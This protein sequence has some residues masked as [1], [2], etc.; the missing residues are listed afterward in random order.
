MSDLSFT[1]RTLGGQH[2]TVLT[3]PGLC[4]FTLE[5]QIERVDFLF[6]ILM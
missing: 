1:Q 2:K 4:N 5:V 6:V 3:T